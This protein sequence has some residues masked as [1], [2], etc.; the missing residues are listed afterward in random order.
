M[1]DTAPPVESISLREA[2]KVWLKIGL[3]SFGGPAGQ[4]AMMHKMLVEQRKWISDARFLHA[5]NYCMLLPGPEA[6]QLAVYIGWLLHRVRGGLIAGGL[7]VLPGALLMLLLSTLYATLGNLPLVV[8]VFFG[9]KPAVLAIVLEALVRIGKRALGHPARVALAAIAFIGIFFFEAPFPVIV[10]GAGL[11]GVLLAQKWPAAFGGGAPKKGEIGDDALIDRL[12]ARGELRHTAPNTGRALRTLAVCLFL[13]WAP[14]AAC[15]ALLGRDHVLVAEGLYFSKAAVMTFGGAYA[16]LAYMAQAAVE[17]Y[18]WL[19]A[20]QMLDG[21][22]LAET[23]PGPLILVTQFVGFLGAF[24]HPSP[25]SPI[26]AGTLGAAMTTWVTFV[27]CFLWIFMGAPYVEALR[28]N[29]RLKGALSAITAAVVGVILNLSLWFALHV[30]FARVDERRFGPIFLQIP[31]MATV[32]PLSVLIAVAA[33]I[34]AF[35]FKV[36]MVWLLSVSAAIG[37][38][39]HFAGVQS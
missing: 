22:G 29:R 11:I 32:R 20:G 28:N 13:W 23:T 3:L 18:G 10:L 5:L 25:F 12:L 17:T 37:V 31:E 19:S 35:R 21:L 39:A 30:L 27:P 24:H 4:I 8:A 7:F 2:T 34:A 6:Q 33:M 36:G 16:V 26:S 14:V 15:V 1:N 38:I 9:I